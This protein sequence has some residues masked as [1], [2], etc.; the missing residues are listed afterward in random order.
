[1]D[2]QGRLLPPVIVARSAGM[3]QD[4]RR[5]SEASI[6]PPPRPPPPNLKRINMRSQKTP[7]ACPAPGTSWPPQTGQLPLA[8]AQLQ[9]RPQ[10][11]QV[12]GGSNLAKMAQMARST[13]QLDEDLRERDQWG[14]G[15]REKSPHVQNRRGS[16]ITQVRKKVFL[17]FRMRL[18]LQICAKW[19]E[20]HVCCSAEGDGGRTWSDH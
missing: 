20:M 16:L 12:V 1:M 13:P 7:T 4:P 19:I 3:H 2:Q 18:L 11:Q 15:E 6:I 17:L 10:P 14:A 5:F 9:P 8:Q